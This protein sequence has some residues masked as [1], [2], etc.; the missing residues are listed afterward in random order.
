LENAAFARRKPQ[1]E[2]RDSSQ[3]F[4]FFWFF[5]YAYGWDPVGGSVWLS[6]VY[7][8]DINQ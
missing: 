3:F 5:F 6:A 8:T 1:C 4:G 7:E 2:L